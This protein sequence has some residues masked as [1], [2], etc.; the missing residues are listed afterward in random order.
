MMSDYDLLKVVVR[1]FKYSWDPEN[2][3]ML[4]VEA[5]GVGMVA[6]DAD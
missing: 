3:R 2:N 1:T 6:G 5:N 4:I